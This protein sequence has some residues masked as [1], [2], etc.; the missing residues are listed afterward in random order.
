MNDLIEK[1]NERTLSQIIDSIEQNAKLTEY[2]QYLSAH[3]VYN[4]GIFNSCNP[5]IAAGAI[6]YFAECVK[7]D[8]IT[9]QEVADMFGTS[10]YSLREYLKKI[11]IV[12]RDR[13]EVPCPN[14]GRVPLSKNTAGEWSF[15]PPRTVKYTDAFCRGCCHHFESGEWLIKPY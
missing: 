2:N 4:V 12:G 13:W 7:G 15:E 6:Y 5:N 3:Q 10:E 11:Q 8:G 1:A 14:C 9:Q